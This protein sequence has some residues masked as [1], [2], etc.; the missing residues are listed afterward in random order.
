MGTNEY[1]QVLTCPAQPD[2]PPPSVPK[3]M[4][5]LRFGGGNFFWPC[6][7]TKGKWTDKFWLYIQDREDGPGP[8]STAHVICIVADPV[9]EVTQ[10]RTD[11]ACAKLAAGGGT[12]VDY[13][14]GQAL[15]DP[16]GE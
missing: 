15:P 6:M 8:I 16:E 14:I 2:W 3:P 11:K 12:F 9:A 1:E 13:T 10:Q 5:L 7:D 4:S